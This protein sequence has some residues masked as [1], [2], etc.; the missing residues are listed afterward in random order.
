MIAHD[1][2]W[3]MMIQYDEEQAARKHPKGSIAAQE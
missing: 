2:D 3:S 1:R